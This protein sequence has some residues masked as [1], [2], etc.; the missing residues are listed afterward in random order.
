MTMLH[1]RIFEFNPL[2]TN[3]VVLWTDEGPS[4]TIVDP[5]MSSP[6]GTDSLLDFLKEHSLVPDAIF[7]THGHFDHVWGVE[8]LLARFSVPVYLNPADKHIMDQITGGFRQSFTFLKHDFP[9]VDIADGD[10]LESG[11][12]SWKVIGTPGHTPG[13]VCYWS[14]ENSLLLSGDTLFAGSIGRTDLAGGDYDVL[15]DSLL[16]KVLTLP[17]DTDVIPGHGQPTTIGRE[18]STNPFL[19]PFNEADGDWWNQDGIPIRGPE[20]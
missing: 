2:G 6:E 4:C 14:E 13:G 10:T 11:G 1:T 12:C 5:G 9:T 18:I 15:M 20:I 7:L 19:Q 16:K 3:C 8:K 17:G